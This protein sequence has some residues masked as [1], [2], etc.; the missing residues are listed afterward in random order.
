MRSA[1]RRREQMELLKL[2]NLAFEG[3]TSFAI[4]PLKVATYIGFLV[5]SCGL[6]YTALI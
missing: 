5:A 3:L 4:A 1:S 2:W 6:A